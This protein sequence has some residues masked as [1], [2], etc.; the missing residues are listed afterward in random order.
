MSRIPGEWVLYARTADRPL[1]GVTPLPPDPENVRVVVSKSPRLTGR[2][3]DTNGMGLP[4]RSATFVIYSG[5]D[6]ARSGHQ[7]F[8]LLP[9]E[10]GRFQILAAPVGSRVEILRPFYPKKPGSITPRIV[11]NVLVPDANPIEMPDL[12]VPAEKPAN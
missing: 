4:L 12:I 9:D 7:R 2:L 8:G 11:A 3:I 1:A 10:Q 5:A 6:P